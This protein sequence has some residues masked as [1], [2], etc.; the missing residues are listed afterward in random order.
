MKRIILLI[1]A[2]FIMGGVMA[3]SPANGSSNKAKEYVSALLTFSSRQFPMDSLNAYGIKIQSR[4]GIIATAL[5]PAENYQAFLKSGIAERVQPS[6][7]VFLTGNE[8]FDPE[9]SYRPH[10]PH[11]PQHDMREQDV[12][13]HH[14][15]DNVAPRGDKP[16]HHHHGDKPC[17]HGD[18]VERPHHEPNP[19]MDDEDA[20]GFYLGILLGDARN[21]LRVEKIENL[22]GTWYP[23]HGI[24]GEL[25]LGYQFN[26]W[27]GLRTAAQFMNKNYATDLIVNK[28]H[29]ETTYSN[30]YIQAPLL[31]D[32]SVGGRN[33]R[34]HFMLG[35]YCG[36]WMTQYRRGYIYSPEGTTGTGYKSGFEVGYN[37]HLD[38]GAAAGLGLTFRL[39]PACL[40]HLEGAYYHGLVSTLEKPNSTFNRTYTFDLG[41]TYHF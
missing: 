31:A 32:F 25:V 4:T 5:I 2:L 20:K 30:L 33:V 40:L 23:A 34:L 28:K 38:A 8:V 35:G 18:D 24:D 36:Y 17:H 12:V 29:Y 39:S 15:G 21:T 9:S 22:S 3:Q 10:H 14:E 37:K 16:C 11:H 26:R 1:A 41:I 6:T 27:F 19:A 13:D 7:R